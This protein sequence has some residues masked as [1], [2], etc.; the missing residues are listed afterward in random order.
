M[1]SNNYIIEKTNDLMQN[2]AE[3]A[4]GLE[5]MYEG[6]SYN[7]LHPKDVKKT[8]LHISSKVQGIR[9]MLMIVKIESGVDDDGL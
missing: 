3:I 6:N 5:N 9:D 7:S 8:I 4:D 1:K 2:L